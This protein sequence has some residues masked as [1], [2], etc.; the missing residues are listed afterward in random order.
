MLYKNKINVFEDT[1][2]VDPREAEVARNRVDEA[3]DHFDE[4]LRDALP[5]HGDPPVLHTVVDHEQLHFE[6]VVQ[7]DQ[8][9]EDYRRERDQ[10]LHED[11]VG[12][13]L[14]KRRGEWGL[15]WTWSKSKFFFS[16]SF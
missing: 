9:D 3:H 10:T 11:R 16:A 7:H 5:G 13:A 14:R 12:G 15:N 8:A 1:T 4:D 6:R 2:P